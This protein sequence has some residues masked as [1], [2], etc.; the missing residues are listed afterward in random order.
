MSRPELATRRSRLRRLIFNPITIK[1]LRA[2]FRQRRFLLVYWI[3]LA[4]YSLVVLWL[5]A[6]EVG[7]SA[8]ST[9]E[10]VGQRIFN[11]CVAAQLVLMVFVLPG[12]AATAVTDEREN[13]SFDLLVTTALR[14]FDIVWGKFTACMV[15]AF[16]FLTATFPLVCVSVLFTGVR[17]GEIL[18]AY[19][20]MTMVASLMTAIG[21]VTS[22]TGRSSR[23]AVG[24]TYALAM[25]VSAGWIGFAL[26]LR[27]TMPSSYSRMNLVGYY[28]DR[29]F[30]SGLSSAIWFGV[31]PVVFWA[32]LLALVF[33]VSVDRLKPT[34]SNKS[35]NLRVLGLVS[36]GAVLAAFVT[37]ALSFKGSV[38]RLA[39]RGLWEL[40]LGGSI[41]A[42]YL[43][44]AACEDPRL[45]RRIQWE[46]QWARGL[47]W[48]LRLVLPGSASGSYYVLLASVLLLLVPAY[49]V[50]ELALPEVAGRAGNVASIAR[51]ALAR[52]AIWWTAD[53]FAAM[54]GFYVALGRFCSTV[55]AGAIYT[56][57]VVIFVFVM[58]N[59]VPV[60][61][62]TLADQ[63]AI[64]SAPSGEHPSTIWNVHYASTF[65]STRSVWAMTH[66]WP[67]PDRGLF[68][69]KLVIHTWDLD[70]PVAMASIVFHAGL[71]GLL[72]VLAIWRQRRV[73][74]PMLKQLYPVD[75]NRLQV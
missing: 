46:Y 41:L 29:V 62:M 42:V 58:A 67:L 64:A 50:A 34:T 18:F 9:S 59:L 17:P 43:V 60:C 52:E 40:V 3:S 7:E 23:R 68:R 27:R 51:A 75:G 15:Y 44:C 45:S 19:A 31:L 11:Y 47:K 16:L 63:T 39:E 73:I 70:Q 14:A 6:L 56:R 57:T 72:T 33:I 36:A 10:P 55:F 61:L 4:V 54:V 2:T 35:T 13:Q 48:P 20:A 12:F 1:E 21:I 49:V 65:L 74:R 8:R 28:Y 71:A 69:S 38:D 24:V 22:S 32:I 26:W 53:L 30:H 25:L 5:A 66:F 37:D